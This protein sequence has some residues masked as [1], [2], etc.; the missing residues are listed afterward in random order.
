[1]ID[2]NSQFFAILTAV[3]EAK[4]ANA[5][6]LGLSWTFAQM[7]VGD[8]NDTDPIPNR[9]QTKL[10][11]EWR[12]APVNQVR[13]DSANP[14]IIITEQVIPAD[15]GGKWIRELALYDADGDMVA[16]ANCAPSFK[17]LLVQGTGK[18]QV[19]R[20]NFIVASTANI[21]LKIDPAVVL[22]TRSYVDSSI[23]NVLPGGR[24]AGSYTK[25]QINERGIVVDGWNPSTLEGYGITDA[26]TKS[27]ADELLEQRV[28]ADT[29]ISAGFVSGDISKP[30]FLERKPDGGVG[31]I[32]NLALAA[33]VH[34]FESL[35][36][37]PSTMQGYGITDAYTKVKSDELLN[38][39]VAADGIVAAGFVS[40]DLNYPYFL[41]SPNSIVHLARRTQV[42]AK[43]DGDWVDAV[44]LVSN[45]PSL[46]YMHQKG[47]GNV[48]L[49][50]RSELPRNTCAKGIPG[51]WRCADTGLLRQRVSVYLGDVS[52]A[53]A[54]SV[55]FPVAF[56]TQADSVKISVL[57]S[58]GSPAT[59]SCSYS[60]L[61]TSGCKLRVDEWSA[62]VQYGLTLIVEAEGY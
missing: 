30:Y 1:M 58:T 24:R 48:L 6:A 35:K 20:M 11:N 12:R 13:P 34:T 33:H 25:V 61:T 59:L 56:A 62:S 4:Q 57:Q 19:I 9:A 39:R 3:G 17:P 50:A 36:D 23:V 43:P 41:K 16:V 28:A 55:A 26:Y 5:T 54:G 31:G 8:A 47:G 15:V 49:V 38:Q 60:E 52:T 32:I 21:V 7:G 14:N 10:I 44:G 40:G 37:K 51:W 2:Q 45:E 53:W 22:A 42:D 46:P 27:R 18:T 29:I